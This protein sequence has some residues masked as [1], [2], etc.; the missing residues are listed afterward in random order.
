MIAFA[1]L[2]ML[3]V[4]VYTIVT[5]SF[6]QQAGAYRT[7][8]EMLLARALLEEYVTTYP[9]MT[10]SGTYKRQWAWSVREEAEQALMPTE[11]DHLFRFIRVT[12]EVLPV[13]AQRAP[14]TL[15]QVI[16]RKAVAP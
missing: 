13:D 4:G 9:S 3:L 7:H 12:V 14:T 10:R 11:A 16:A 6:S 8:E 5:R 15:S 2:S 1:V